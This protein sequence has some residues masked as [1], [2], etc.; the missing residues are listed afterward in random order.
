MLPILR[1][2]EKLAEVRK[3]ELANIARLLYI[4]GAIAA[5]SAVSKF[6][7]ASLHLATWILSD[8][9]LFITFIIFMD[10]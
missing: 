8:L 9:T 6:S 7:I 10:T 5:T 2:L 1:F 3:S 4:R